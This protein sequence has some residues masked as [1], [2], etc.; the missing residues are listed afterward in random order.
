MQKISLNTANI[1][2]NTDAII[3]DAGEQSHVDIV[4][5]EN[6]TVFYCFV[7]KKAGE[8]S[9]QID[10]STNSTFS[11]SSVITHTDTKLHIVTNI[12]GD[13]VKSNL[14]LLAIAK[15]N[16]HITV[17]WVA[18]VDAP[19]RHVSTRVDQT[20]ILLGTGARISA[21]PKLEVATDDI[22]WG[23]SCK[24]HRLGWD[25]SFYLESRWLP[26]KHA[27]ALLLNSEILKHLSTIQDEEE[28]RKICYEIHRSLQEKSL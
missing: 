12:R 5:E 3:F 9:R 2:I 25:A 19:Y 27:E 28:K 13:N 22:E 21:T 4:I 14:A 15:D 10:I 24:I 16:A 17:E 6:I 18:K 11:W 1:R 8:F 26:Q 7:P 23:H 20:N